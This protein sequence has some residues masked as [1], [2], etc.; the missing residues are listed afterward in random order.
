MSDF[1]CF[2]VNLYWIWNICRGKGYLQ[3]WY[4]Y[5]Q[6]ALQLLQVTR[7]GIGGFFQFLE[8]KMIQKQKDNRLEHSGDEFFPKSPNLPLR[9]IQLH[10]S[11]HPISDQVLQ[12]LL[13]ELLTTLTVSGVWTVS[14]SG[15]LI[16][17][18]RETVTAQAWRR[19][20]RAAVLIVR[21]G[22]K[23]LPQRVPWSETQRES[24]Q[25]SQSILNTLS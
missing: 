13:E 1:F 15:C 18:R 24:I 22:R 8:T 20:R 21:M 7:C 5:V 14:E 10:E 17:R 3:I 12:K 9:W 25:L 16:A 19:W 2:F 6:S 11:A 23:K 4:L